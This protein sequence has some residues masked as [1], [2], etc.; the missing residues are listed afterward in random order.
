MFANDYYSHNYTGLKSYEQAKKS[1]MYNS[2]QIVLQNHL[3][4]I[5]NREFDYLKH[6]PQTKP[7]SSKSESVDKNTSSLSR[8]PFFYDYKYKDYKPNMVFYN[9]NRDHH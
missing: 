8:N 1:T 5:R 7:Y 6:T 3:T 4:P 2:G 9:Y